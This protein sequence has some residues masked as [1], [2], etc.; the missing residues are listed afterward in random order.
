MPLIL[1]IDIGSSS[2]R[3]MAYE[4]WI[5]GSGGG[6]IADDVHHHRRHGGDTGNGSAGGTGLSGIVAASA[7]KLRAT[8]P[9]SGRI[10]AEAVVGAVDEVVDETIQQLHEQQHGGG[11]QGAGGAGPYKVIAVG[12]SSFVMNLVG[13]GGEGELLGEEATISYACNTDDVTEEVRNLKRELG[14]DWVNDVYVKT[15]APIHNAY[16]LPQLRVLY[17]KKPQLAKSVEKWQTLSSVCLATWMH[18]NHL[19]ISYSEASWTGLM[20]YQT[21][22]YEPSVLDLLPE[23]CCNALPDLVDYDEPEIL[24]SGIPDSSPY[25][26]RWP[27]LRD[28]RF[29]LGLGDGVCANIGSKV[30]CRKVQLGRTLIQS[31][32]CRHLL[33]HLFIPFA[34]F[35]YSLKKTYSSTSSARSRLASRAQSGL[36]LRVASAYPYR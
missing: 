7:R 25:Y 35:I 2:V 16:S 9:V 20:N 19:P 27:A 23:D 10:Y 4:W 32:A 18:Q 13:V 12:L 22:Q 5:N 11:G 8:H 29:F 15:G 3:C 1:A 17:S 36:Q 26:D 14:D 31:P 24:R 30:S 6:D 33:T 28:A 21:C 34:S